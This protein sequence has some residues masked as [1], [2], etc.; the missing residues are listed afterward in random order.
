MHVTPLPALSTRPARKPR[1]FRRLLALSVLLA[2]GYL[3]WAYLLPRLTASRN[4]DKP[5]TATVQR[6]ELKI[7]ITD[8]GELESIDAVQVICDLQGGGKLVSIVD[9][10][11][12]VKKGEEVARLDT[13]ALMKLLN[14]Q[15]VKWQ[16][17]EGKVKA[18]R[19]ELAQAR[20]KAESEIAKADV[21][22]LKANGA[23]EQYVDPQGE[24]KRDINKLKGALELK[25]KQLKEAEDD[26]TFTKGLIKDGFAQLEQLRAKE[27]TVQQM[28]YEV[29]SAED[30]VTL[31]EKFVRTLKIAELKATAEEAARELK[32]TKETQKSAIEKAESELKSAE[33][34]ADIEKKQ[35]ARLQQQVERCTITAPSDGIVVYSNSRYWDESSRIRP[36]AQLYYRQEIFSLPDLSRMRVKMKIHE[37]VIKK[38]KVGMPA[39]FQIDALN[40]RTLHGKVLKIA[41]IAQADGWRGAG[42]KQYETELSLDDMPADGG[43]KPGMTAEVKILIGTLPDA[44]SVPVAGVTEYE[45]QKVVYVATPAGVARREVTVGDSNEQYVQV[46][47]GL[48]PGEDVALDARTRAAADL[49]ATEKKDPASRT[50]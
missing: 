42:V 21:A 40:N 30:E 38:V 15:D 20:N 10:G 25:K 16:T 2:A 37:S 6:G 23:Y 31:T 24:Y 45:S 5:L 13:D 3:G 43:L 1:R 7:T 36:G 18:G 26:L 49:K 50:P 12:R 39:A 9:E 33:S 28:K 48:E 44:V 34:T 8:H 29:S 19:S 46:T 41:T 22:L 14:E 17:A 35:L 47:A 4:F 11:K 27:L 32:R